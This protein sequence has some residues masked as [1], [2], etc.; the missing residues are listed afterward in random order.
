MTNFLTVHGMNKRP[1]VGELRQE[2]TE[3]A[4]ILTLIE[5]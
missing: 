4:V 3:Y 5:I 2:Y 1:V